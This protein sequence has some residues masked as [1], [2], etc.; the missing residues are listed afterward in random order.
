MD[1][2]LVGLYGNWQRI[3]GVEG[4]VFVADQPEI[5]AAPKLLYIN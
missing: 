4:A 5:V 1:A 2:N 3:E